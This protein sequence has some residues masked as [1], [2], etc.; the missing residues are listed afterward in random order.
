[1]ISVRLSP[2][3]SRPTISRPRAHKV[4]AS[5]SAISRVA[6]HQRARHALAAGREVA[7]RFAGLGDARQAV[8]YRLAGNQQDALV[9]MA[10]GRQVALRH[11]AA[12]A[13]RRQGLD[14]DIAVG[15]FLQHAE[16][17][18]AAHAVERFQ[19]RIA[20]F[21]D[22]GMDLGRV[23]GDQ[24]GR[25]ELRELG[26]GYFF[27]MVA[28]GERGLFQ[29]R[30]PSAFRAFQQPGGGDVFEIEGRVLAHQYRVAGG[31]RQHGFF[32]H[33]EPRRIAGADFQALR[34]R[35]DDAVAPDQGGAL[36]RPHL[37]VAFRRGAHHG[38]GRILVRLEPFQR[39]ED[40]CE[41][42]TAGSCGAAR[43]SSSEAASMASRAI[44]P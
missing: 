30:A 10:D 26:D 35:R 27:G 41:L 17:A 5:A 9:A 2:I 42:H 34:A 25:R 20:E 12:R 8:G 29:M 13:E 28:D 15:V 32:D 40:E 14:D 11:D 18:A 33:G 16:D 22:E 38:H 1:L 7:A 39:V 44:T 3:T 4:G 31:Q 19:D 36:D 21:V 24:R 37:V 43:S 6:P 23:A